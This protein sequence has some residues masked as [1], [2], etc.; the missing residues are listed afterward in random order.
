M[1]YISMNTDHTV[2]KVGFGRR[3]RIPDSMRSAIATVLD[4]PYVD[5][6]SQHYDFGLSKPVGFAAE[7][8]LGAVVST[9]LPVIVIA[10]CVARRDVILMLYEFEHVYVATMGES[11]ES[12]DSLDLFMRYGA[13]KLNQVS[14]DGI[15]EAEGRLLTLYADDERCIAGV[16]IDVTVATFHENRRFSKDADYPRALL[17]V[18]HARALGAQQELEE[19]MAQARF[20][21]T[22]AAVPA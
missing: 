3:V 19:E 6:C 22:I 7:R 13:D 20:D 10:A 11:F 14:R 5:L 17:D 15:F 21:H 16:D 4:A 1:G 8:E 9:Q 2:F 18:L 12:A